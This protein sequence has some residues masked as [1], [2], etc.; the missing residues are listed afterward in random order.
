[1]SFRFEFKETAKDWAGKM[2]ENGA[3]KPLF[4]CTCPRKPITVKTPPDPHGVHKATETRFKQINGIELEE[5]QPRSREDFQKGFIEM[6]GNLCIFLCQ[7]KGWFPVP[8]NFGDEFW[9]ES[10]ILR[11]AKAIRG[12]DRVLKIGEL[13]DL[14]LFNWESEGLFN[15]DR[16]ELA[17]FANSRLKLKNDWKPGTIWKT[18]Y[19]LDL[20]SDGRTPGPKPRA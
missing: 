14:L 16:F 19:R 18:A 15:L 1:M 10:F 2:V 6:A 17:A 7:K 3:K 8:E 13:R 4:N 5:F 20:L 11:I 9:S 12:K